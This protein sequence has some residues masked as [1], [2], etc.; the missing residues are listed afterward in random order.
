MMKNILVSLVSF[1]L[2]RGD[3]TLIRPPRVDSAP[4]YLT[5]PLKLYEFLPAWV[6]CT[7]LPNVVT[8]E[9]M[10]CVVGSSDPT[11]CWH[12]PEGHSDSN[13]ELIAACSASN[14]LVIVA[15]VAGR[16]HAIYRVT[17]QVAVDTPRGKSTVFSQL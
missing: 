10:Q 16:D 3:S 13:E 8:Q 4:L 12:R 1:S 15:C 11:K 6:I 7:P 14:S 9:T 2:N 17:S 5:L